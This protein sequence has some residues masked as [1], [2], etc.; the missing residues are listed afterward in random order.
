[1]KKKETLPRGTK[2]SIYVARMKKKKPTLMQLQIQLE[3]LKL[4]LGCEY[5]RKQGQSR[6]LL[7]K[8]KKLEKIVKQYVT[9]L[10]LAEMRTQRFYAREIEDELKDMFKDQIQSNLHLCV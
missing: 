3:N 6:N 9:R 8:I 4:S 2:S 7:F 1:M 10:R 5:L